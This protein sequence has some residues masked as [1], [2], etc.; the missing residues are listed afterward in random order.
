MRRV[1]ADWWRLKT[2]LSG[3]SVWHESRAI[4]EAKA[5]NALAGQLGCRSFLE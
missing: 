1:A 3:R 2:A 5:Y 4:N